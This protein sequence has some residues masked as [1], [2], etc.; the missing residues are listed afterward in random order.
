MMSKHNY[1]ALDRTLQDLTKHPVCFGGKLCVFC[2]DPKQILPVVRHGS[3]A[4]I[5]SKCINQSMF[6]PHVKQLR[7]TINMRVELLQRQ[8]LSSDSNAAAE[9]AR[10]YAE[11]LGTGTEPTTAIDGNGF[12]RVPDQMALPEGSRSRAG[13]IGSVFGEAKWDD[14][15]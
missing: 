11:Y 10:S 3:P 1:D 6:W 7:L 8:R 14:T 12:I 4:E 2:G 9:H 5:V 13:L 15:D